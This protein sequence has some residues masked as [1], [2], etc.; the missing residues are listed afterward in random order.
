MGQVRWE[1]IQASMQGWWKVWRQV[2]RRRS[3]PA[4]YSPR[5]TEQGLLASGASLDPQCTSF[6]ARWQAS[7]WVL[8]RN[9]ATVRMLSELGPS[10]TALPPV[11]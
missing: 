9:V 4:S 2:S 5:H 1:A 3:A 11:R 7:C 6:Q 10:S 8:S